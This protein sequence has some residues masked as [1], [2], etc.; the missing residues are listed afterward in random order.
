MPITPTKLHANRVLDQI[1]RNLTG[2]QLD[3]VRNAQTHKAMAQAQSP[4]LAVLQTFIADCVT[5]YQRR[6]QWVQDITST[7]ARRTALVNALTRIGCAESDVVDL[8]Q[9]LRNAANALGSANKNNYAQI[10]TAC[11]AVLSAVDK[12]ESL[13][14]E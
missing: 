6:L 2:L 7:P 14:P 11:D 8:Y 13:W 4:A 3:M 9:A 1:L 5:E 12:P 10:I